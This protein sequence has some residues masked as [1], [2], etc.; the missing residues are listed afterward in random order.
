MTDIEELKQVLKTLN[1]F[2]LP[3]SPILEYAIKEKVEQL[4]SK[5]ESQV[6]MPVIDVHE[7]NE[8][9]ESPFSTSAGVKK[10]VSVLR[11]IRDNGTI[12]EREFDV[13][14]MQLVCFCQ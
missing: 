13:R 3:I 10:K 8:T 2:N 12:I 14:V 6:V 11:V 4:S 9:I 1:K 7:T 5:D